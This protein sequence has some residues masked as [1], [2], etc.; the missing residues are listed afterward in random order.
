VISTSELKE[1]P[2]AGA[3]ESAA[4]S[5]ETFG[6]NVVARIDAVS[7]EWQKLAAADVY[8]TPEREIVLGA[9]TNP[10]TIAEM[11]KQNATFAA[12][13]LRTYATAV[14]DL[15]TKRAALITDIGASNDAAAAEAAA[16]R[17]DEPNATP[18]PTPGADPATSPT[19]VRDEIRAFNASAEQADQDCADALGRLTKYEQS[20][21]Q[22]FLDVVG[23]SGAVG[24]GVGVGSS[25]AEGALERWRRIDI[26]PESSVNVRLTIPEPDEIVNGVRYWKT[27]G[28]I[29]SPEPPMAPD[30]KVTGPTSGHST[31]V[32]DPEA[33]PGAL[34]KWAKGLGKALGLAGTGLTLYS[35]GAEQ[36]AEDAKA[37]PEWDTSQRVESTLENV[38]IVGGT[39]VLLGTI[40]AAV[41]TEVGAAA[42]AAVGAGGGTIVLPVIGTIG[43]G[44]VGGAVGAVAGG[45]A[46]GYYGG[47][48]GEKLGT[49]IKDDLYDGSDAQRAVRDGWDSSVD[50]VEDKWNKVFG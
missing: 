22:A 29:L 15:A 41:G 37:H 31:F 50:W 40:G 23:G 38:V 10:A 45:A 9:M 13:A 6:A 30:L 44:A 18:T 46:G 26:V 35:A 24:T 17:H 36:W 28:G 32:T 34:P 27:P 7:T 14:A 2:D 1:L 39:T 20:E 19:H 5:F 48:Y 25:L 3:L 12:Q 42:G 4:G 47:K 16:G 8:Q 33:S 11:V 49:W 21:V 43:V